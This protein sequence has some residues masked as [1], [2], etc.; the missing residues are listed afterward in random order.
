MNTI[1]QYTH[2]LPAVML[3]IMAVAVT[4]NG[5]RKFNNR[6]QNK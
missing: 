5:E 6:K 4:M 3:L 2:L 1:A